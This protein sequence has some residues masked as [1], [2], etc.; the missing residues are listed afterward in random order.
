MSRTL[1][2]VVSVGYWIVLAILVIDALL[3][4]TSLRT[5]AR[6]NDRV[7]QT[8]QAL[9]EIGRT[10]TALIN[11]ETGQRGY[12]LTGRE[13]Y[14][15][16]FRLAERELPQNLDRLRSLTSEND[17]Q[18][19]RAAEL[20]EAVLEKMAELRRTIVL[21]RDRG[22]EA[23]LELV[24][25][26]SGKQKMDQARRLCAVLEEEEVR[27]LSGR[28]AEARSA[29]R[30][31][32][33]SF[34][35]TTGTALLLLVAVSYLNRRER[36]IRERAADA[37]RRE[38]AW[39]FT[40]LNSIGDAVIAT[41]SEGRIRF[42]NPVA[43]QITAWP[44]SEA[45][46]R[47]VEE[48]FRIINE[49]TRQPAENPIAKVIREGVV[50][51]LANH[52]ILI[53][54]DGVERPIDDSAAPIKDA[55]GK[56]AGVVMVFRDVGEQRRIH[57]ALRASEA[58]KGAVL[59]S[60]FDCIVTINRQGEIVEFNPAAER[61]FG[62][63]RAE[64]V[65]RS[66]A[67]LMVPPDSRQDHLR[68]I[69]PFLR[70][71]ET[72]FQGRRIEVAAMRA[73]GSRIPVEMAIA[74][75]QLDQELLFTAYLRDISDRKRSEEER[76]RLLAAEQAARSDAEEAN[77]AKD[78]FLAVLSHELRT[79]L[80]PILLVVTAMLERPA[81]PQEVSTNLEMI[82]QNV[83]LQA[84][85][86]DDLLDMMRI[87]R[88]K[89][90]LQWEVADCNQMIRQ[91]VHIC[92]SEMLS[93]E[94]RIELDLQAD[95][96]HVNA[97]PA[98]IQQVLWNL[99]KNAVK[100]TPSGG[101][102]T[103]RTRNEVDTDSRADRLLIEVTDT[104]IGIEPEILVKIFDPFQQGESSITRK[105]GGMGLGL[106]ISQ[107][108]IESHGGLLTA[109]SPGKNLGATFRVE[110]RALPDPRADG[111]GQ[112]GQGDQN[113]DTQSVRPLKILVVED[114]QTT[115]RLMAKLLQRLGH[116]V[117]T[118]SSVASALET[119]DSVP[120]EL[121][122]SDIGLPDGSGF[123]LMRQIVARRGPVTSIALTGY[124]MEED[125]QR[126]REAGFS[127]HMTKPIDFT[128]LELVI[129]QLATRSTE[130][131]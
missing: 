119:L 110:L 92:R 78:Q 57:D 76:E 2:S 84:R 124:G 122:I 56:V 85:L 77:R 82:R 20:S 37:I 91:A 68:G 7:D 1:R 99:I 53:S 30:N 129:Q 17:G 16:P 87:V 60:A 116:Q 49:Y 89:L 98:R 15:E 19:T 47:P 33:A 26:D 95:R 96:H 14:L 121:I 43:E 59:Q 127:A 81:S 105:F 32:D 40:T 97:D 24:L 4:Y 69:A 106:A 128:K 6:S 35:I 31:A 52:T 71:G 34:S 12:L 44:Q 114:E 10:L 67:E 104:G 22:M 117:V 100:F 75:I 125:I 115:L 80:N 74:P 90:A 27:L 51:G 111:D 55:E 131:R 45:A 50:V 93:K 112:P 101:T 102:I 48:V 11:A 120:F 65:G 54:K 88:G 126:S 3:V 108:I 25:T 58:L 109:D 86:I 8:R 83:N 42:M 63:T 113:G 107:G 18:G 70:S 41:D 118:A 62:Y 66:M 9:A 79:P 64:A 130:A 29:V 28:T 94:L 123:E 61:T 38:Q 103:V 13:T 5:I 72:P 36:A 23:A 73:D 39:L 21:R 46:D